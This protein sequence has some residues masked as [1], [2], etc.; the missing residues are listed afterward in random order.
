MSLLRSIILI[1][2]LSSILL[3]EGCSVVRNYN[4]QEGIKSFKVQ[5]YRHAFIRLRPEAEKGN[6]DAQYAIGFMYYYGQ[7]VVENRHETLELIP[8]KL[9]K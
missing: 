2:S 3:S 6:P 4:L 8:T 7:G 1:L 9:K 5:N